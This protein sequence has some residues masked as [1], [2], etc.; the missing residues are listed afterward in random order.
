MIV[1]GTSSKDLGTRKL[2]GVKSPNCESSDIYATAVV[3][4]A[5]I[6]WI[7]LFPYSKKYFTT[8]EGTGQVLEGKEMPQKLKDKLALEK[9]HFKTPFYLFS[10]LIII[11]LLI[12]YGFYAS[13]QHDKEMAEHVTHIEANDIMVFR[14]GSKE[15]SFAKV[16][17]VK[18]DSI[19]I[20]LG[21]YSYEGGY[22]APTKSEFNSKTDTVSDFYAET[23][24]YILQA[25][26]NDLYEKEE[27]VEIYK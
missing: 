6:F 17:E 27:L 12:G 23:T 26:I 14:K 18:N 13:N 2:Q 19:F 15:Y 8:C 16:T 9:H 5:H 3:K 24:D 7:P 10:G 21:Q 20:K 4:Y 22:S 1:Y 25:D 11:A